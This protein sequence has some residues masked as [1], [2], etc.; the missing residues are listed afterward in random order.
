M[1]KGPGLFSDFGKKAKDVLN[2]DY[3]PDQKITIHSS[4]F[5]GVAL[6]SN[7][8]NKGGLSSGDVGARYKYE[9]AEFDVKLETESNIVTTLS[10]TDFLPSTKAIASIKLPDYNSGKFEVQYLHQHA[11]FTGALGL[12][13]SPA[14]DF[15]A[16]IGTPSIAFGAEATYITAS[17]EF[18]KYNTGVSLTKPDSN[19]S[20]ILADK[21]DSIRFSSLCNLNQ[22]NGGAVVGEM[23]R[24]F[25][26]NENTLTVG[27]SYVVD[28]Q[29]LL[30][31]KLNNHG[32]LGALVQHELMP[33]SFLTIS[34]AF[35]TKALQNTPKFGLALSLKP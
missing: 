34:G 22:L 25:S 18:A 4:S 33:K 29:T 24:R 19:A 15:S 11:S 12:N 23:S 26:T 28:P 14:V 3:S 10:V 1:S 27:F 9:N 35:D 13:K 16:A 31:A 21:G 30:K 8:A 6:T 17:G 2:K 5:S 32:N 7:V 20:V